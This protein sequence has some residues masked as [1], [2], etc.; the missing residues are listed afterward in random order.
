MPGHLDWDHVIGLPLQP[1]IDRPDAETR[2]ETLQEVVDSNPIGRECG[3]PAPIE[4]GSR[5]IA[6]LLDLG[7]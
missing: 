2:V 7:L 3:F 4:F 1:S 6:P 5:I